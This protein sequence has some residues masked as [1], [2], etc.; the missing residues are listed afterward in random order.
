MT[1]CFSSQTNVRSRSKLIFTCIFLESLPEVIPICCLSHLCCELTPAEAQE[2]F[3]DEPWPHFAEDGQVGL[4]CLCQ[5]PAERCQ[6]EEMQEGSGH[7]TQALERR[8]DTGEETMIKPARAIL[9]KSK[10]GSFVRGAKMNC[11]LGQKGSTNG[12]KELCKLFIA[13]KSPGQPPR[14]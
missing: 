2:A 6:E 11:V 10:W 12:K 3:A 8:E 1:S 14:F 5:H 4:P 7:S 13:F 9:Q